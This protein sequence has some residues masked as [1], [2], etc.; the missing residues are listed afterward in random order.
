MS[1]TYGQYDINTNKRVNSEVTETIQG[2]KFDYASG[3]TVDQTIE[4]NADQGEYICHIF[5]YTSNNNFIPGFLIE[6]NRKEKYLG[7]EQYRDSNV[8][9][10][11]HFGPSK[12]IQHLYWRGGWVVDA[13]GFIAAEQTR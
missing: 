3:K 6:T 1:I 5:Q 2:D 9:K 10:E 11:W 4:I 7:F 12:L 8:Q 13:I